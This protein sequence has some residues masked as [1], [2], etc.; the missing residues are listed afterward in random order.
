MAD[1]IDGK[2][3]YY[4]TADP[5]LYGLLKQFA[6]ENRKHQTKAELAIWQLL[7]SMDLGVRFRRQYIIMDYIADFV[8]LEKKLVIEVDGGYHFTTEQMKHDI[9]RTQ[10]LEAYGYRVLRFTNDEVMVDFQNVKN[11]II[12]ELENIKYIIK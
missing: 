12:D 3:K 6:S 9:Y 4:Q 7:G 5:A 1:K 8:C 11:K 10:K 2:Y